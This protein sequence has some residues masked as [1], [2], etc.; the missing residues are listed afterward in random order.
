M[1]RRRYIPPYLVVAALVAALLLK[2]KED[3][4]RRVTRLSRRR[5]ILLEDLVDGSMERP[6][7]RRR[8]SPR[9][10]L[11]LLANAHPVAIGAANPGCTPPP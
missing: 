11:R 8:L 4:H 7:L 9:V 3:L 1:I 2:P 5:L 10:R 6:R